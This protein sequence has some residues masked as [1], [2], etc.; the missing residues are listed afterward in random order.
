MKLSINGKI[1]SIV[2]ISLVLLSGVIILLSSRA[3][4]Q[5]GHNEIESYQKDIMAEKRSFLTGMI[6]NAYYIAKSNYEESQDTNVL[7]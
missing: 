4:V 1:N 2:I 7:K 6:S 5:R 3:L